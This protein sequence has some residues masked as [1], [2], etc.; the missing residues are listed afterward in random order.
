MHTSK[1][2][3]LKQSTAALITLGIMPITSASTNINPIKT[4]DE[5][6]KLTSSIAPIS[7]TERLQRIKKAQQLMKAHDVNAL[8]L[9]PGASMNY[10]SGINWWRSERLTSVIIPREGNVVVICPAFEEPSVRESL[11]IEA[12]IH[13]WNEHQ[14]PFKTVAKLLRENQLDKGKIAFEKSVRY[15]VVEGIMN[16]VPQ[17]Y[18]AQGD[19]IAGACRLHKS[20][21]ELSLMHKANEITLAAYAYVWPRISVGMANT[22]VNHM[23]QSA[24]TKLGGKGAWAMT[25]INEASALPHGTKKPQ[26]VHKGSVILMDCG[27]NVEGYQADISRTFVVGTPTKKQAKVWQ[28]VR[29]G[30]DVAFHTAQ[31]LS[32]IHI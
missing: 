28:L 18:V 29:Q 22:E 27:C 13:V 1:R 4:G 23:M 8:V 3:F 20:S 9:E 7:P 24:L 15:F 10:F 12:D 32:L 14:S 11:E 31:L 30:Q 17:M 26:E 21:T 5:L 19:V 25:L 2:A 6:V 16:E